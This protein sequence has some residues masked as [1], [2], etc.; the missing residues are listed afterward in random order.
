MHRNPARAAPGAQDR[1]RA[2]LPARPRRRSAQRLRRPPA[3]RRGPMRPP[4]VVNARRRAR[5]AGHARGRCGRGQRRG[6]AERR[7]RRAAAH[8]PRRA[9]RQRR[10]LRPGRPD[11]HPARRRRGEPAHLVDARRQRGRADPGRPAAAV[12][13][14]FRQGE[15][16]PDPPP[17][18]ARARAD[19]GAAGGGGGAAARCVLEPGRAD[20]VPSRAAAALRRADARGLVARPPRRPRRGAGAAG[21]PVAAQLRADNERERQAREHAVKE[22]LRAVDDFRAANR[23]A[24]E[25]ARRLDCGLPRDHHRAG[26][27][28]R[29]ARRVHRLARRARLPLHDEDR[30]A[31]QDEPR[32]AAPARVRRGPARRRQDRRAGHDPGQAGSARRSRSGRYAPPPRDRPRRARG[33]LLPGPGAR[34]GRLPPRALGRPRLSRQLGGDE[35]PLAGRIVAVADAFDA[36]TTDRP[37]REGLRGRRGAGRARAR[38]GQ[39]LRPADRRRLRRGAREGCLSGLRDRVT[40]PPEVA[41]MSLTVFMSG[42][43]PLPS[44]SR[45]RLPPPAPTCA[46]SRASRPRGRDRAGGGRRRSHHRARARARGQAQVGAELGGRPRPADVPGDASPVRSSHVVQGQRRDPARRA[47]DDADADAQPRRPAL[48]ARPGRAPLGPLEPS[49]AERPDLRHHRAR[50]FRRGPGADT[51]LN[52]TESLKS[53]VILS[54]ITQLIVVLIANN[55]NNTQNILSIKKV[56]S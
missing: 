11:G 19:D 20:D 46:T 52:N 48:A 17:R 1:P 35:I 53:E 39:E 30:R 3:S 5:G 40:L 47:R 55:M 50:S 37:Y 51:K 6:A 15:A 56:I 18:R 9:D 4:S 2:R 25:L 26:Q 34:R 42:E 45:S 14:P 12:F 29:G 16:L 32:G 28:G 36:M 44:S 21:R 31:A 7:R 10:P 24:L 49:R 13:E 41:L 27:G 8:R 43:V 22:Q 33:H 23:H 38:Q 54:A